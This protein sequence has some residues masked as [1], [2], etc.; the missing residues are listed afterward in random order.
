VVIVAMSAFMI[1]AAFFDSPW[2]LRERRFRVD[3]SRM[4]PF[5]APVLGAAFA[6][7]W[8]PCLGPVLASVLAVAA[9]QQRL[10]AGTALLAAYSIG[11][12]IPFLITGIAYERMTSLAQR[13]RRHSRA[14]SL[15]AAV[16]LGFFGVL[17]LLNRFSWV[18]IS[19]EDLLRSVGLSS[20]TRL[21]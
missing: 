7:G 6:F 11:L 10:A 20:L 19:I 17:L 8:T 9:D 15:A 21:G 16:V 5:A 12:G 1:A 13:L 14:I 4:G 18:V 2:L 3:P